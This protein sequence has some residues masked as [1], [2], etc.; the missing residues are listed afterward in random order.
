MNAAP[1]GRSSFRYRGEGPRQIRFLSSPENVAE[2]RPTTLRAASQSGTMAT[3]ETVVRR[4]DARTTHHDGRARVE[5]A[6]ALGS[7]TRVDDGQE[8]GA[9][10]SPGFPVDERGNEP[11]QVYRQSL[12]SRDDATCV[13]VGTAQDSPSGVG[14]PAPS[15]RERDGASVVVGD[16]ESRSHGEGRQ[17]DTV[18]RLKQTKLESRCMDCS[19]MAEKQKALAT[20]AS[21]DPE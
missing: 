4:T 15:C 14:Q 10:I 18:Q 11:R 17:S 21:Q 12:R 6:D 13:N 20:K 8:P 1:K 3:K 5:S 7:L 19:K 2:G 9:P 16:R